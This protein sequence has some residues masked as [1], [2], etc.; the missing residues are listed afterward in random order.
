MATSLE[1]DLGQRVRAAG[2]AA[3]GVERG[4]DRGDAHVAEERRGRAGARPVERRGHQVGSWALG[5]DVPEARDL[6]GVV[7]DGDHAAAAAPEDPGAAAQLVDLAGDVR[8]HVVEEQRHLLGVGGGEQVVKMIALGVERVQADGLVELERPAQHTEHDRP[9]RWVW[10]Q[11]ERPAQR[12]DRHL[13]HH[14]LQ[15]PAHPMAHTSPVDHA[16]DERLPDL[17]AG[18]RRGCGAAGTRA[19]RI[20]GAQIEGHTDR[21]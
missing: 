10:P 1:L 9:A 4:V 21:A 14:A 15:I 13:E 7:E 19:T 6:G 16:H 2:V 3:A 18:A 20:Q 17:S 8:V 12:P 5:Q 11:P